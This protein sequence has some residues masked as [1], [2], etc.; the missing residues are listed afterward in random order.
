MTFSQELVNIV[1]KIFLGFRFQAQLD[2][3]N[4]LSNFAMVLRMLYD[5]ERMCCCC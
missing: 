1:D 2:V 5:L 4:I 3:E